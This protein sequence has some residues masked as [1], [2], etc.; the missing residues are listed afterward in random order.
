[1]IFRDLP[2]SARQSVLVLMLSGVVITA[3]VDEA[4]GKARLGINL[5]EARDWNTALPFVDL[6]RL[7][8]KWISQQQGKRFGKGPPLDLDEHGWVKSLQPGC[9]ADTALCSMRGGHYPSGRYTILYDGKGK[10]DVVPKST[11]V[12]FT[13]GKAII[14]VD[15]SRGAFFLRIVKT[16]PNDYIRNIRVIRPGFETT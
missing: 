16:D 12:R 7:S 5:A 10:M 11:V 9:R 2:V 4:A 14:D 8:R 15:S 13:Q 3:T 6:F 1:M